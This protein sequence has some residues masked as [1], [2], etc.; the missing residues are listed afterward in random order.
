[1]T[2]TFHRQV[3]AMAV[4][5]AIAVAAGFLLRPASGH[6]DA[7][8]HAPYDDA[9]SAGSITLCSAD[10]EPV[11]GGSTD[12]R[13]FAAYA[14]GSTGLPDDVDTRGA[15]ATLFGYQPREGVGAEEFSGSALTAA[16]VLA[17]PE[18][19][20]AVI[21]A[22]GWSLGDFV[23]AFPATWDGS[24]QLRLYLGTPTAGTLSDASYD[25]ADLRVDG[26]RWELVRGGTA[27]CAGA[28]SLVQQ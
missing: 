13:P 12:D 26:D 19:P 5:G 16:A 15:V 2:S 3:L 22:D 24:V 4:V 10:G 28:A 14:V 8:R 1:M 23:S 7:A 6:D 25:T 9:R 21:S 18:Q 11:T 17:D 20:A 27:S